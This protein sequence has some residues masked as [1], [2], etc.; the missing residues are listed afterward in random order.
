MEREHL[1]AFD[2]AALSPTSFNPGI[3]GA[4][5][6]ALA[7]SGT[8]LYLGGSFSQISQSSASNLGAL[9]LGTGLPLAFGSGTDAA[10]RSLAVQGGLLYL[11]GDFSVCG[12]LGRSH[13]AA[14]DSSGAA[15]AFNPGSD[16]QALVLES[17]AGGVFAGGAFGV[18]GAQARPNL[19]YLSGLTGVASSFNPAPDSTVMSLLLGPSQLYVGGNFA[20]PRSKLMSVDPING[21]LQSLNCGPIDGV[22]DA[23]LLQSGRLYLGGNFLNVGGYYQP[24]ISAVD[25]L[26][27]Q[28]EDFYVYTDGQVN[29]LAGDGKGTLYMGGNFDDVQGNYQQNFA[30]INDASALSI[31]SAGD[32]VAY[33]QPAK[34]QVCFAFDAGAAGQVVIE[35][36]NFAMQHVA[37]FKENISAAGKQK[38][39]EA[40]GPITGGAYFYKASLN[41]NKFPTRKFWVLR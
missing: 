2:T 27:G 14:V 35:V 38:I 25:P 12:S 37:T 20:Q 29:A 22:V 3:S 39:C 34:I 40:L 8:T 18:A 4:T 15:T 33:P 21:A 24:G 41:G 36:Y 7:L 10:V 13:L 6:N 28:L 1:A 17:Y 9:D 26:S 23:L 11:A 32:I 16:N 31:A 30:V 19:A 5:V